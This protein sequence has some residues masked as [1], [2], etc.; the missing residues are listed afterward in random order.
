MEAE[1]YHIW[2][3]VAVGTSRYKFDSGK[4]EAEI[5]LVLPK[6]ATLTF[7][8]AGILNQL[9]ELATREYELKQVALSSD[10]EAKPEEP[11]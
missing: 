6:S 5:M 9:V 3:D 7:R 8:F 1:T 10:P 4:G 11:E 2:I